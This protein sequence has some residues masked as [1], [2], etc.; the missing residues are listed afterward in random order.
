M[1]QR[2]I[3]ANKF[4]SSPEAVTPAGA[5]TAKTES[6]TLSA[7]NPGRI[8]LYV[9]NNGAKDVWLAL[10]STAVAEKGIKLVAT[11]GSAVIDNYSGVVSFISKEG[12]SLVTFAE[13]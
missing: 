12:E 11:T 7:S 2:T 8:A 10:G 5:L 6:Q 13:I 4:G 3:Q 9:T 1:T